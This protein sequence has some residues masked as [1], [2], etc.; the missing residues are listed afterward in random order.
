MTAFSLNF[1]RWEIDSSS[2]VAPLVGTRFRRGIYILEF[3]NGERY[4]GLTENIVQR[5]VKSSSR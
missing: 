5:F 3:T 4:V 2:P 1:K